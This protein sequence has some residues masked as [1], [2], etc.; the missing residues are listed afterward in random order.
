[1]I[2]LKLI[3]SVNQIFGLCIFSINAFMQIKL[4]VKKVDCYF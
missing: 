2:S 4:F 1:M 3:I